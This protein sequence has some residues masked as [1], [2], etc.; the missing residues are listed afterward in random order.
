MEILFSTQM[1]VGE[2]IVTPNSW[3]IPYNQ[4]HCVAALIV[5]LYSASA[6]ES[7]M[8]CFFLLYQQMEPSKNIQTKPEADFLSMGSPSQSELEN[9]GSWREELVV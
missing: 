4:T 3:R 6:N 8:V 1:L 9:R 2:S 5:A 7:E